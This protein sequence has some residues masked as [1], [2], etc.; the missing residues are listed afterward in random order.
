M[1]TVSEAFRCV[2]CVFW[3][4]RCTEPTMHGK[5]AINRIALSSACENFV[6]S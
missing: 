1:T 2:D 6:G 5:N 4:G 3:C